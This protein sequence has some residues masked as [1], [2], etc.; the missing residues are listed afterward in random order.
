MEKFQIKGA[1][2]CRIVYPQGI[3][4][5]KQVKGTEGEPKYSAIVL[6][7]KEDPVKMSQ[8]DE[9]YA[10]AFSD[11]QSKG[12]K[13]RRP[14]TINPKN[15]CY[16]DGDTYADEADGREA[17]R[18]YMMLKVASKWVRPIVTD[19]QKRIILNGV[20]LPG[21]AVEN[22]SDEELGDGDY[23]FCNVSFWTYFTTAAQGIGCNLNAVVRAG[24]GER[25]G[26]VSRDVT[27]YID[28]DYE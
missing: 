27:D 25:I 14:A 19:L 16:I 7:P 20:P 18:G 15:N 10:A 12:F 22:I 28:V 17:F 23:I 9:M 21:V 5:K 1:A 26:G 6:V 13:G 11:L 24:A 3:F 4:E 2:T 8:L